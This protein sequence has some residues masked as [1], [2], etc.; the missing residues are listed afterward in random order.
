MPWH[1][2][3]QAKYV[4]LSVLSGQ[5]VLR[6][7]DPV[8][9]GQWHRVV[10][11]RLNKDG[12]LKVD[13][14]REITRSSPGKAQGLNIHTPMYLGGVPSMDI[15]PKP[16]NVSMLFDGCIGEVRMYS[17]VVV[18][19]LQPT[20]MFGNWIV[21]FVFLYRS[22][23]MERKWISHTASLRAEPSANVKMAAHVTAGLVCTE[24]PVCPVLSM[25][26]SASALKDTRVSCSTNF[27]VKILV[28]RHNI[29]LCVRH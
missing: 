14:A 13:H 15:L 19:A 8:S 26:I 29:I 11:E 7:Q 21:S 20:V 10:A 22:S 27:Q 6:S 5:A 16:A 28:E 25:S 4:F 18:F 12:S 1:P 2:P 3:I 23:S 24:A 9:L 17:I